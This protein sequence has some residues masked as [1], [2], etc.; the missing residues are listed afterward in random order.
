M[1]ASGGPE[2][3]GSSGNSKKRPGSGE[4]LIIELTELPGALHGVRQGQLLGF[5][6]ED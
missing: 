5:Q 3:G 6:P 1:N 4:I 2:G